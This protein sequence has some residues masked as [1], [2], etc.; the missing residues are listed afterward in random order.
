MGSKNLE[1]V[2]DDDWSLT[3]DV[4]MQSGKFTDIICTD[5]PDSLFD[6][7]VRCYLS[8]VAVDSMTDAVLLT[9][10][11]RLIKQMTQR[12]RIRARRRSSGA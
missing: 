1:V 3:E 11:Q 4:S 8:A 12:G 7:E 5:I 2:N 6:E 9:S 10:S